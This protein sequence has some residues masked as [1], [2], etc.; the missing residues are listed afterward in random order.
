MIAAIVVLGQSALTVDGAPKFAAPYDQGV[1]E[2]SARL[3]IVDQ[4][5]WAGRSL[6]WRLVGASEKWAQPLGRYR[7][8]RV[9]TAR[10]SMPVDL[11]VATETQNVTEAVGPRGVGGDA[12]RDPAV[13]E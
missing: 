8:G 9:R 12:R 13:H 6:R 5:G 11:G 10:R 1:V 7:L 3:Q 4:R 2:H